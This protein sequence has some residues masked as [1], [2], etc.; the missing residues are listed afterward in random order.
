MAKARK[1][2]LV[3]T[4]EADTYLQLADAL[5][6]AA[7]GLRERLP[8][9]QVRGHGGRVWRYAV[10]PNPEVRAVRKGKRR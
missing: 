4:A 1:L 10:T 8:F 6:C 2:R 9:L 5:D 3:V 7:D